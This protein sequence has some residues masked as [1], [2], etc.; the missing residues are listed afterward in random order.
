MSI[1]ERE[2]CQQCGTHQIIDA[3]SMDSSGSRSLEMRLDKLENE[4]KR[5]S[6]AASR[7]FSHD[8]AYTL[9]ESLP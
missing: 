1:G 5:N 8:D 9:A 4:K 6:L 7:K 3:S 2:G